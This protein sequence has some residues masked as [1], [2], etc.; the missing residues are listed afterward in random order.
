MKKE[1]K[2][3]MVGSMKLGAGVGKF[4]TLAKKVKSRRGKA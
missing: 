3:K 1:M 2:K 4:K